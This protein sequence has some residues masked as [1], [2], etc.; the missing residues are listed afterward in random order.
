MA[1]KRHP[2]T[3]A[4]RALRAAGVAFEPRLYDYDSGG[5]AEVAAALGIDEHQVIKTL[6]LQDHQGR[7]L[8]MLM[9]GDRQVA[10]GTLARAMGVKALA[11][12]DPKIAERHTGYR[13]GGTSPFGTR[14]DLPVY[15]ERSV[16]ALRR[17]Y[18]N[19]GKRGFIVGLE[20][21]ELLRVLE[22]VLVEAAQPGH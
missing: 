10:T 6:I 4:V 12:C 7:P 21:G 17:L 19:G 18:I 1:P 16:G 2:V 5:T 13:V 11:P 8:I 15:C 20:T 14:G 22:P 9:H 3:P